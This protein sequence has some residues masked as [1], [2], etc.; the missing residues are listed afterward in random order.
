MPVEIAEDGPSQ[1]QAAPATMWEDWGENTQHST[2]P[3]LAVE[4]ILGVNQSME[5]LCLLSN[6]AFQI[7][8]RFLKRNKSFFLKK[9]KISPIMC[10]A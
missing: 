8:N 3:T 7:N 2:G 10:Q 4:G 6:S 5:D 1:A 9:I